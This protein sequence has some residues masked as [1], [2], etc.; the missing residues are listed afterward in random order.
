MGAQYRPQWCKE[1]THCVAVALNTPKMQEV[2][3]DKKAQIVNR[4]WVK[5]CHDAKQRLDESDYSLVVR[6]GTKRAR[7]SFIDDDESEEEDPFPDDK[8]DDTEGGDVEDGYDPEEQ[9]LPDD[10]YEPDEPDLKRV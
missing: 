1:A 9:R 2:A 3:K 8:S 6:R 5:A 10:D 4:D 7:D